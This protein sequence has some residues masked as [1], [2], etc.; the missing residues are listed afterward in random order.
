MAVKGTGRATVA[1]E[2]VVPNAAS[3]T[4]RVRRLSFFLALVAVVLAVAGT[5]F[6]IERE[7]EPVTLAVAT[8]PLGSDTYNLMREVADVVARHS[9]TVRLDIRASRDSSE[10]IARLNTHDVDLAVIR[11]DTPVVSDVRV[12]AR[13]FPDL[14]Q[15]IVRGD[16]AIRAVTDLAS[17]SVSIPQFGTD[18]FRSFWVL[19]DHYDLPIDQ[20]DWRAEPFEKGAQRLLAG[21]VDALFTIRSLRDFDLIRLFE[22][23]QLKS[24]S[25][26]YVPVGQAEAIA[27]KRP[28]L[29]A[30]AIPQ[31][32]FTGATPVPSRDTPTAAVD[33]ILVTRTGVGAEAIREV[34]RI[35]FEY[36]LDLTIRFALASAIA[37]PD[38]DAGLSV[39]LHEGAQSFYNRD[40]PGFL[41]ENAEPLALLVTVLT[42]IVSALLA[43]RSRFVANQ[44]NRADTYNYQLL[45]IQKHAEDAADPVELRRLKQ[46][47]NAVLETVVVAL[48]TDAVTDEGFQS[49]SLLW[50]AVRETINDRMVELSRTRRPATRH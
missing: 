28:F 25:L 6:W 42:L 30:G 23:A 37:A 35:L 2:G 29:T 27:L 20:F 19:G 44:K 43:L 1:A 11:S 16:T 32:A 12:I 10:N 9:E 40:Q 7:R 41:Q 45:E 3:Y 39:P 38:T 26:R 22:D 49:F 46:E 36:R 50:D 15:I 33:R 13:L 5:W 17:G 4:V 34:T 14:F 8:G 24:I 18:A 48:D 31:G 21:D 47:L